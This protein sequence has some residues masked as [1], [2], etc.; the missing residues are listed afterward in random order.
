MAQNLPALVPYSK[1]NKTKKRHA[2]RNRS[3]PLHSRW[4]SHGTAKPSKPTATAADQ[5]WM[6]EVSTPDYNA[7][8]S[9]RTG[10]LRQGPRDVMP[11]MP[12]RGQGSRDLMPRMPNG[13][14]RPFAAEEFSCSE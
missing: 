11:R 4:E 2:R 7:T 9:Q 3:Q 12:S 10:P 6:S 1:G 14:H 8:S 13:R 5:R